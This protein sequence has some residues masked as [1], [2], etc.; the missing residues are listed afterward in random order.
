MPLGLC[1]S[2]SETL[3]RFTLCLHQRPKLAR[4]RNRDEDGV[5]KSVAEIIQDSFK[6]CLMDR[7]SG[8]K[9]EGKKVGVYM[10]ANLVLKLPFTVRPRPW[11]DGH[12][13]KPTIVQ[14]DEPGVH[15]LPQHVGQ[16][17]A[18]AP[19][20][21]RPARHLPLLPRPLQLRRQPLSAR[22]PLP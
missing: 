13:L 11:A 8:R 7:A 22:R 10:F 16:L 17:A 12:P 1:M 4:F 19:L 3:A 6:A 2:L 18:F 21:G 14:E 5:R 15:D 9:P 20:P